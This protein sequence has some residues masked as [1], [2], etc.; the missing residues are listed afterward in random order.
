[1]IQS[2]VITIHQSKLG[3]SYKL[4]RL[5]AN[6]KCYLSSDRYNFYYI[7]WNASA[8][9]ESFIA[10]HNFSHDSINI[11][12]S[13]IF[14]F[15][16]ENDC[17]IHLK[18]FERVHMQKMHLNSFLPRKLILKCFHQLFYCKRIINGAP[19]GFKIIFYKYTKLEL[20]NFL[21][22]I[23]DILAFFQQL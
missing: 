11:T 4:F 13:L 20:C 1:M 9:K 14:N 12:T 2:C 19:V 10:S 5:K 8:N 16:L 21:L 17:E 15:F 22:L 3:T 7:R 23:K 6:T 18:R